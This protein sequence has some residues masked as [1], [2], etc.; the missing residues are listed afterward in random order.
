MIRLIALL[1]LGT[2]LASCASGTH[3]IV[4]MIPEWAGGL[5]KGVPPRP[6]TPEYEVYR[7][8]VDEPA[9][10]SAGGERAPDGLAGNVSSTTGGQGARLGRRIDVGSRGHS[11]IPVIPS[12]TRRRCRPTRTSAPSSSVLIYSPAPAAGVRL[13][14]RSA[15]ALPPSSRSRLPVGVLHEPDAISVTPRATSRDRPRST[16]SA[17]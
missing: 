8:G 13:S 2:A 1:I 16:S 7:K 14:P 5:P 9:Q 17:S 12:L 3:K 15:R 11:R 10:G 4:D 6:G